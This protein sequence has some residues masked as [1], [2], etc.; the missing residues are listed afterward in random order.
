[1]VT[2]WLVILSIFQFTYHQF[3]EISYNKPKLPS[4]AQ[5]DISGIIFANESI[6]GEDPLDIFI[7]RNNTI[8]V[9]DE[10]N[11][12]VHIWIENFTDP[13]TIFLPDQFAPWGVFVTT[14]GDMYIGSETT[15]EVV[16][17]NLQNEPEG[18]VVMN[19]TD[20]CA[21]LFVDRLNHLYCSLADEHQVVKQ[22]LD[23]SSTVLITVAGNGTKG[24][25][26][27]MLDSPRGIFVTNDLVLYVA[28]CWNHRIQMF[29]FNE[30]NATTI[31]ENIIL[32]SI[33]LTYPTAVFFDADDYLFIV[34]N[35]NHRIIG[36]RSNGFYC[37]VGCSNA[38]GS[39][40]T[41]LDYPYGA[42]FDIYGNIFVADQGN[43][44]IQKFMLIT[45]T[46]K[47]SSIIETIHLS[48]LTLSSRKS[49]DYF[50]E[51]IQINVRENGCYKVIINS[52]KKINYDV[53]ENY[54]KP[55]IPM[56]NHREEFQIEIS[57]S[58]KNRYILIAAADELVN[59]SVIVTG[60]QQVNFQN[61]SK[62]I[63][64]FRK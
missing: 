23:L 35:G 14:N 16:R 39:A 43:H 20:A 5:W 63:F 10:F 12:E 51:T 61:I 46:S 56:N 28:D 27:N 52:T 2:L 40:L 59:F 64:E 1:M 6:V 19:A 44:R 11:D 54:L 50:Y 24:R 48:A 57:M 33:K 25:S 42:T 15:G 47:D 32:S 62:F 17:W 22:P 31:T 41:Q 9:V 49:I 58:I 53:Y 38:A 8:Y 30:Q 29:Q 60:P 18:T 45:N 4:C 3:Q 34:D 55:I 13:M 26:P 21:G 37:L 36:S 7:D